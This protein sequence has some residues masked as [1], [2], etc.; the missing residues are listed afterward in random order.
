MS[1]DEVLNVLRAHKAI[2]SQRFGVADLA[3]FE[4]VACDQA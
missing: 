3:L 2:L 4:S 1:R